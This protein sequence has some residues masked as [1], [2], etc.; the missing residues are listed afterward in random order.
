MNIG[1]TTLL[2]R[3]L[4]GGGSSGGNVIGSGRLNVAITGNTRFSGSLSGGGT[5]NKS[6]SGTL[7]IGSD[8][9]DDGTANFTSF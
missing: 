5:L 6:G 1:S 4:A 9:V 2:V 3:G 7:T 8:E